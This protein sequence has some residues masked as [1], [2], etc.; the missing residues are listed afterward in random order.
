MTFVLISK[1]DD[2]VSTK[3]SDK[4]YVST[5]ALAKP[6][7]DVIRLIFDIEKMKDQM[8]E[9][10]IDL[11]KMPLGKISSN[12]IKKAFSVLNELSEVYI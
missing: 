2:T 5:S 8:K 12:Q 6:V 10:E 11:N 7:Q 3:M 9:F 1:E 4:N